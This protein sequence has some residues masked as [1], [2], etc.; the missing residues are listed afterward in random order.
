MENVIDFK[1]I[2]LK[3]NQGHGNARR[4][5]LCE[6]REELVALMD[7]DD[8]STPF[9]F[10][11][12]LQQFVKNPK[13]DIVGGQISE[14]IGD[15]DHI[16][17][18]REV[19]LKDKHIKEFM[20]KRCPMNQVTVMFKKD[21][22]EQ[23]GGYIDWYCE[24]DYYLW[25][26]MALKGCRF[27]NVPETVVNV[28]V[29]DEM[30]ARRGGMRYF[31]SEYRMQKFLYDKKLINAGQFAYNVLLRFCGEI[32]ITDSMRRRLFCLFRKKPGNSGTTGNSIKSRNSRNSRNIRIS[33]KTKTEIKKAED[34]GKKASGVIEYPPFSVSMCVY[35]G[36]NAA[37]FD[38][39]LGSVVNQTV[40]P[41]EI[42][43]VV[44]GPIPDSIEA[45]IDKYRAICS[46]D[47]APIGSQI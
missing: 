27:S 38:T 31:K 5:G 44:D 16:T 43:L 37:W 41:Q 10:E 35:G 21:A 17:G 33:Q 7:S 8:I 12:Q 6:C 26:R 46:G 19:P 3:K 29:G 15:P 39:A 23:S 14:F 36:D 22:V 4:R 32:L 25:A 42:V 18:I 13:L 30:S 45:V 11:R 2:Y 24:E 28:R 40:K 20:R 34:N 47:M 1:P 9:R